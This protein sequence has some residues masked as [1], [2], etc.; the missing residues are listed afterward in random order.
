MET[1]EFKI[2]QH[3][4]PVTVEAGSRFVCFVPGL[5]KQCARL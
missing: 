5:E 3:G 4:S 2:D 1:I